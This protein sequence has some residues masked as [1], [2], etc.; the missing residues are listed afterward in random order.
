[1]L[2]CVGIILGVITAQHSPGNGLVTVGLNAYVLY[3][4][5]VSGSAF[6]RG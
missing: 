6:R 5:A 1:V 4:M 3:A 2:G